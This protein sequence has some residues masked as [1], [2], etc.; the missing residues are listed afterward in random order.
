MYK[1]QKF[2]I[3]KHKIFSATSYDLKNHVSNHQNGGK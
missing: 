2:F 3:S 1:A